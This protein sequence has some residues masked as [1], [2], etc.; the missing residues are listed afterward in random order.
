MGL[1][2]NAVAGIG[3]LGWTSAGPSAV[4]PISLKLAGI[5][6]CGPVR[7]VICANSAIS[8][9]FVP[10]CTPGT[11]QSGLLEIFSVPSGDTV[12]VWLIIAVKSAIFAGNRASN[13]GFFVFLTPRVLSRTTPGTDRK[14]RDNRWADFLVKITRCRDIFSDGAFFPP[15]GKVPSGGTAHWGANAQGA[16]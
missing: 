8:C 9:E 4:G 14:S 2:A 5:T 3:V 15:A 11:W 12:G 7:G 10:F 6:I 16:R 1:R 13:V